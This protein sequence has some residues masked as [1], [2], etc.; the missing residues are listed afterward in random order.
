M[1]QIISLK[2]LDCKITHHADNHAAIVYEEKTMPINRIF[3]IITT[4][5]DDENFEHRRQQ[6]DLDLGIAKKLVEE[7]IKCF[8]DS[9]IK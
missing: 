4:K 3:T 9:V 1:S 8:G 5:L 6:I 2:R 7:L